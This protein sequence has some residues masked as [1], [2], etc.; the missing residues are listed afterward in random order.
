LQ[1][2]ELTCKA[3]LRFEVKGAFG[4]QELEVAED[5]GF[6]FFRLGFGVELLEFGDDLLDS[7][8]S[9]AALYDFK[10]GSVEAE[11]TLRHEE[12]ALLI[13]VAETHARSEEGF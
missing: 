7:M 8:T 2:A 3:E 9:V 6:H 13:A 1:D 11:G 4:L 12:H 10:T 5:V